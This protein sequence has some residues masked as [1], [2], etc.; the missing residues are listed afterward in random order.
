MNKKGFTLVE[1]LAIIVIL[2]VIVVIALP[3][4]GGSS[5][6]NKERE[7]EKIIKIIESAAKVYYSDNKYI[8]KVDVETLKKKPQ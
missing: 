1:L 3:Q 2:G 5:N 6:S 8:T 7:Y 4:I